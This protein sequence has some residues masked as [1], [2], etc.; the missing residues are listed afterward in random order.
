[1]EINIHPA[2]F[3]PAS[4]DS[5]KSQNVSL[6]RAVLCKTIV[7]LPYC[8]TV[9]KMILAVLSPQGFTSLLL[10]QHWKLVSI[11]DLPQGYDLGLPK[12]NR[13][14]GLELEQEPGRKQGAAV[15]CR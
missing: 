10:Q 15:R 7:R 5:C 13:G 3:S 12:L 11:Q 9:T 6:L 8:T 1:M 4:I 2:G 14:R